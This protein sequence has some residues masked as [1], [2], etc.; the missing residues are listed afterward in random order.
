MTGRVMTRSR[1]IGLAGAALSG[2]AAAMLL[3][4]VLVVL[5]GGVLDRT[6]AATATGW[7]MPL[8]A[9]LSVAFAAW[10]LTRVS[11]SRRVSRTMESSDRVCPSCGGS[12]RDQWRLCPHCGTLIGADQRR[13]A[14]G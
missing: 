9:G 13:Q 7:I 11:G 5:N 3:V 8:A 10:S 6:T 12:L 2:A 4:V 14:R 1:L